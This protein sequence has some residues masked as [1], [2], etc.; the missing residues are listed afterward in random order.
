MGGSTS[1]SRRG[2]HGPLH[3]LRIHWQLRMNHHATYLSPVTA[4]AVELQQCLCVP[5]SLRRP[6]GSAPQVL[7]VFSK[8]A[9]VYIGHVGLKGYVVCDVRL[10]VRQTLA[11]VAEE[12]ISFVLRWK[13]NEDKQRS[14]RTITVQ[15][16]T[17]ETIQIKTL[18]HIA[19]SV[20]R[21]KQLM[22]KLYLSVCDLISA[23]KPLNRFY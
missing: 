12:R 18:I 9:R 8:M 6:A 14:Y 13:N 10:I 16:N 20:R 7:A 19:S 15:I 2:L 4:S 21:M 17:V 23:P 5:Y 22:R 3:T 11:D 1:Y